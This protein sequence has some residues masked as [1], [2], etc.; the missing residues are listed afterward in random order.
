MISIARIFGAPL[1]VPAGKQER[2]A[3]TPTRSAANL[4]GDVADEMHHVAVALDL[5]Q[6]RHGDGARL[7]DA[8][9]VVAP[10]IDQHDVLGT[11]LFVA[12]PTRLASCVIFA[13]AGA[14]MSR[15][16]DGMRHQRVAVQPHQ[17]LGRCADDLRVAQLQIEH[18]GRWI[19]PA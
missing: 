10:E 1:T 8:A 11:L 14:A 7:G 3:S 4:A 9:D 13:L 2:S 15:S 12:R 18:V 5:H 17:Q 16:G 6:L 19:H